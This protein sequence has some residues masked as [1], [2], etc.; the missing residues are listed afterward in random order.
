MVENQALAQTYLSEWE[1][2]SIN[3]PRCLWILGHA[4]PERVFDLPVC[5]GLEDQSLPSIGSVV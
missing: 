5:L 1:A 4:L 3:V 2:G